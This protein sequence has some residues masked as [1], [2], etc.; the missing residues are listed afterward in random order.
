MKRYLKQWRIQTAKCHHLFIT[1]FLDLHYFLSVC[2]LGEGNSVH[3][4]YRQNPQPSFLVKLKLSI[5]AAYFPFIPVTAVVSWLNIS[6]WNIQAWFS[7]PPSL[8]F[9][10][11]AGLPAAPPG[12]TGVSGGRTTE[13]PAL[14]SGAS[15]TRPGGCAA[16]DAVSPPSTWIPRRFSLTRISLHLHWIRSRWVLCCHFPACGVDG[17]RVCIIGSRLYPVKAQGTKLRSREL[18]IEATRARGIIY[19]SPK[20]TRIV[21]RNPQGQWNYS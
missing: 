12:S 6:F 2:N 10:R 21:Y 1:P 15:S 17:A 8:P 13:S 7:S 18:F 3:N 4:L 16:K 9:L 14:A 11:Q 19:R 20:I 5:N